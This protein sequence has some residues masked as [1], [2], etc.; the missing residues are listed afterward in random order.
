ML[1]ET[2]APDTIDIPA[3]QDRLI[4]QAFNELIASRDPSKDPNGTNFR[5]L[6]V[7]LSDTKILEVPTNW[8]DDSSKETN[9]RI[10]GETCLV[11]GCYRI[12]LI[13]DVVFKT[14]AQKPDTLTE[15]PLC[16]PPS[17]RKEGLILSYI[18][19]KDSKK[20]LFRVYPYKFTEN[21]LVKEA[22]IDFT[23]QNIMALDSFMM[24]NISYGFTRAAML[25]MMQKKEL[26]NQSFSLE[27]GD[28]MLK[29][30]LAEFPGATLGKD[31]LG[32]RDE[33]EELDDEDL[34]I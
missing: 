18:D 9:L 30:V 23:H 32:G 27:F 12:I 34:D 13:N 17:M 8:T 5:P 26:L 15:Q 29:E 16:Y 11:E 2:K 1:D 19:F 6:A 33:V 31:L 10:L 20:N 21:T 25:D 28:K 7:I 4:E 24:T 3:T 22:T 14:Y